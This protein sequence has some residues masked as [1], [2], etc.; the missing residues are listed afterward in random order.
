M[1]PNLYDLNQALDIKQIFIMQH[2]FLL[3]YSNI[4]PLLGYIRERD[5]HKQKNCIV[6][7]L[8][9]TK[10]I[11]FYLINYNTKYSASG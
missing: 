9:G 4:V 8:S 6:S 10:R 2:F 11:I 3:I 7:L 5:F 1:N